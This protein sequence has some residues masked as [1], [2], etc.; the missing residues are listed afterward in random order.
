MS[1]APVWSI[2]NLACCRMKDTR[3]KALYKNGIHTARSVI[4]TGS[5][6]DR[7]GLEKVF[8]V[9]F[10]CVYFS[11]RTRSLPLPVLIWNKDLFCSVMVREFSES[12][13]EGVC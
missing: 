11:P 8:I 4:R 13:S 9:V 2:E 6:S 3:E 7:V 1:E 10:H 5:G 12:T